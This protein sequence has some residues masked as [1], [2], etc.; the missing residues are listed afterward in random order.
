MAYRKN[1]QE[2]IKMKIK[3]E[4]KVKLIRV[5]SDE[6]DI[7]KPYIAVELENKEM[8]YFNIELE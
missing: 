1:T 6:V 2:Y 5:K 4:N 3:Y 8:R 7:D